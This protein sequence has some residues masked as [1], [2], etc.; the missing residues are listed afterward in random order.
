MFMEKITVLSLGAGV[1]SSTLALLAEN[2][3]IPRPDFA[4]FADTLREPAYVS[5]YLEFLKSKIKSFPIFTTCFDDLGFY[6]HK[7]PF[8]IKLPNGDRAM[9]ARQ[10]TADFKIK[11]VDREIRK[12]LGYAKGQ[13]MKHE[14]T[15]QIGISTDEIQRMKEPREKW[16]RHTWPLID[17]GW[18]RNRCLE[19][20]EHNKIQKPP[21]SSCYFCPFKRIKDWRDMRDNH[22]MEWKRAIAFD[23]WLRNQ[24]PRGEQYLVQECV[25]LAELDLSLRPKEIEE[26][27]QLVFGFNNE[28]EGMCGV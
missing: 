1:Q 23:K 11:Q 28:C 2:G 12:Q 21:K 18:S 22:P 15:L 24:S 17:M 26:R 7:I 27:D 16:K 9:G 25:P 10:C 13:R 19:Y 14:V 8:F 6:P 20:F 3:E 4:V 5:G